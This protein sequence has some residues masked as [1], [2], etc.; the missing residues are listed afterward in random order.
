VIARLKVGQAIVCGV[1][2]DTASWVKILHTPIPKFTPANPKKR[3][4]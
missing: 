1:Q 4:S 3:K 2:D